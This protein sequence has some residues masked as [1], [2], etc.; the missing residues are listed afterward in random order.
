MAASFVLIAIIEYGMWEMYY[1]FRSFPCSYERTKSN[2][3]VNSADLFIY[4]FV[5]IS[6]TGFANNSCEREK[7]SYLHGMCLPSASDR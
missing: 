1:C 7:K 5:W 2:C 6:D 3:S 4:L